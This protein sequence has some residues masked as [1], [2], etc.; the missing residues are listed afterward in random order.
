[1][2]VWLAS[3][4]KSGNTLVRSLLSSYIFSKDG[5]FNFELLK[6]IT[7]FP[8]NSLFRKLGVDTDNEAE[9]YK[10]YINSQKI[11]NEKSSIRFLK[12]HSC[13]VNTNKFQFTDR[14]NTL[15]VIYIVRDPRNIVTSFAHHFQS[16]PEQASE[17]LLSHQYLGKT[18]KKHCL[19][20][21]GSWKYHYNSWK[22]FRRFNKY[23]LIRYEDLINETEKTFLNILK[24]IAHL[25]RVK[26][27]L[28]EEKFK[29]TLNSTKFEKM[30]ELETRE[31]FV[32]AKEDA[33]TGEKIKFFN[34]GIKN[35][36]KK[37]LDKKIRGN[38]EKELENEMRE[39]NY[40]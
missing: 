26:F 37:L 33:Q 6:N 38:L 13:F 34:L 14:F 15:G 28:N 40:L 30:Q 2:I 12:T 31:S 8:D 22:I 10:N 3:Y 18:S 25:G 39:L 16:S 5:N 29:N 17:S 1:M 9:M 35:D 27:D 32:E 4:P 23:C 7:Q 19:T 11:I 20:Y 21:L 36:W 24:F